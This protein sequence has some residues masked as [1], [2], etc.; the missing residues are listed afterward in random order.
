MSLIKWVMK[1][2]GIERVEWKEVDV[3]YKVT[4]GPRRVRISWYYVDCDNCDSTG[5][6]KAGS[7][8]TLVCPICNGKGQVVDP[9]GVREELLE[10]GKWHEV[11]EEP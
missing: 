4:Y 5:G 1:L 10:D 8:G 7:F 9:Q 2:L 6:V 11:E 3:N